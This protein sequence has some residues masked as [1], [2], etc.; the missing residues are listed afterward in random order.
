MNVAPLTSLRQH[1]ALDSETFH[2]ALRRVTEG[3]P[4]ATVALGLGVPRS[5]LRDRL[6]AHAQCPLP[7]IIKDAFASAEG[8]RYAARVSLALHVHV[9]NVCACGL[10]VV[11]EFLRATGLDAILGASL[12]AQWATAV[13]VDE[14]IVAYADA[15]LV[16]MAPAVKGKEITLAL[17]ENFHEGPCLVGI[18]PASNFVVTETLAPTRDVEQWKSALSP[19]LATL[20]VNVVQV[21]SDSGTAILALAENIFKA[22]HSPDLFHILY[23]FQR[24]FAPSLRAVRRTLRRAIEGAEQEIAVVA[25]MK[26]RWEAMSPQERGRGRAPDFAALG[27]AQES[28]FDAAM[29]DLAALEG[30]EK[31]VTAALRTISNAYHPICL[32]TGRRMGETSFRAAL[33][34]ALDRIRSV[35]AAFELQHGAPEA[36]AK[37]DKMG[38]KMALTLAH[39]EATWR[40]RAQAAAASPQE[41]FALETMLA[42]AS[43][44]ERLASRTTVLKAHELRKTAKTLRAQAE[45]TL[46][47]ERCRAL[48]RTG[49]QMADDFQ[50]SSSMVEGRN[51]HLSLRHHAFHELSL[52]KRQVLTALHNFVLTRADGTTAAERFSGVKPTSL[53]D[54]LCTHVEALPRARRK[55]GVMKVA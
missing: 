11:S 32:A 30:H 26:S 21:T 38:E 54:W 52:T 40:A 46:G 4:V 31:A 15:Q 39:I 53:L 25:R 23:D 27:R 34:E 48:A 7:E 18:E 3:E 8:E 9:R 47:E 49:A 17:D 35:V 2:V 24:S 12:G 37:L 22:H 51:G 36:L 45:T 43:Y 41:K 19:I 55:S 42:P 28:T 16:A 5:T 44:L 1:P 33:C 50:R 10:R 20:G 6:Q 13:A 29:T 14:A